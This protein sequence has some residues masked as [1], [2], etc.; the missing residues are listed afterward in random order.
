MKAIILKC[1]PNAQFHLGKIAIDE[2]TSLNET[3]EI[4]H[5]D[6]L[7]SALV[8]VYDKIFGDTN[9]FIALF[10]KGNIKI[11]S[12]F[13]C[14]ELEKETQLDKKFIYFLPKPIH[15]NL[16]DV[17]SDNRKA[18]KKVKY[19]SLGVWEAGTKPDAFETLTKIDNK[20]VCLQNEVS[21]GKA[22][23]LQIYNEID[24][25]K[26][27]VHKPTKKDSIYYQTNI[28]I[29]DNGNTDIKPHFY[30]LLEDEQLDEVQKNRLNTCLHVLADTG[31]GGERSTGCGT[32]EGIEIRDFNIKVENATNHVAISLISPQD[33]AELGGIMCYQTI[34]RGGRRIGIESA[35][36][37]LK[38]V[39]MVAEGALLG[40][41]NVKGKLVD[42]SPERVAKKSFLRNGLTFSL[43]IKY[44]S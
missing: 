41:K 1:K 2:D 40:H 8:N 9:D 33:K 31:I 4:I 12:C 6:T 19:I 11:S 14:L 20:F 3:S 28:Q 37:Y 5:S 44:N 43:P 22:A 39:R 30:F 36:T 16:V 24:L 34:T 42:I 26:V 29:A 15:Y 27:A 25:P 21:K 10:E 32:F 35:R 17:G 23:N 38:Q 13:Y 7:F 18:F